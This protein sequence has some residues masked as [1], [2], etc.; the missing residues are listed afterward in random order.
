MVLVPFVL[1]VLP[2]LLVAV[3]LLLAFKGSPGECSAGRQVITSAAL[4]QSYEQHWLQFQAQLTSGRPASLTVNDSEATSRTQDF[5]A[6]TGAPVH[7][8]RLCFVPGGADVNGTI[9]TPFGANIDVRLK[10]SADLSGQHPRANI[11]SIKIGGLPSFVTRPFTGLVT[12]MVDDQT[13]R[14][15]L[16]HR[17]SVQIA[18]GQ[19]EISGEP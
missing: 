19:A 8:V 15:E 10:G 7:D 9:S 3:A 12:R 5:L 17:L 14:V 4:S 2:T 1:F 11:D 6:T 13:N 16:D 18:E